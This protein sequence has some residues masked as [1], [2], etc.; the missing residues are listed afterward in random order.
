MHGAEFALTQG[1]DKRSLLMVLLVRVSILRA[2][3]VSLVH[4]PAY[5]HVLCMVKVLTMV[6]AHPGQKWC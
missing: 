5:M 3:L 6:A 2:V 1:L 4:L